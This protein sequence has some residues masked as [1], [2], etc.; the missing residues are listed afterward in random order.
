MW[1]AK[2]DGEI[3]GEV[4]ILQE[5]VR[6]YVVGLEK[7]AR[8]KGH[9]IVNACLWEGAEGLEDSARDSEAEGMVEDVLETVAASVAEMG[10]GGAALWV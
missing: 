1:Q 2:A 10:E 8:A 3:E 4:V 9:G 7:S 5:E 6:Q